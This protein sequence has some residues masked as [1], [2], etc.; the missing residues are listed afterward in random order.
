MDN[1]WR[2]EQTFKQLEDIGARVFFEKQLTSSDV[3][4]SG[5]VVVP[6]AIAE[7]YLPRIDNPG[8]MELVVEDAAGDKYTLRFR[9]WINNQ[10]RMY[11]LE[12]TAELQHHLHLKMGDVLIFAQK[13]DSTI[14]LAGP[15]HQGRC[16]EEAHHA[17]GL[18]LATGQTSS[19]GPGGGWWCWPRQQK[20]QAASPAAVWVVG[21][22]AGCA[23]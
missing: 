16:H 1:E 8:G 2:A 3:S 21:G 10:S 20:Q 23:S 5:R 11:L 12:G 7:Q 18:T 17:Q 15:T 4:A 9:F 19:W 6:K 13:E 14:V 22:G